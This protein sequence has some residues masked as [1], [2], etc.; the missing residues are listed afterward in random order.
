MSK[1]VVGFTLA[2]AL[3]LALTLPLLGACSSSSTNDNPA[4]SGGTGGT[5]NG[6]TGAGGIGGGA[7]VCNTTTHSCQP[8][9]PAGWKAVHVV[10]GEPDPTCSDPVTGGSAISAE[11]FQCSPCSCGTISGGAC[12]TSVALHYSRGSS[13]C[14]TSPSCE[15]DYDQTTDGTCFPVPIVCSSPTTPNGVTVPA[16]PVTSGSCT[17]D[18]VVPPVLPAPVVEDLQSLCTPAVFTADCG[19]GQVCFENPPS[20]AIPRYCIARET[21]EPCPIAYPHERETLHTDVNDTRGCTECDCSL[22]GLACQVSVTHFAEAGC[23]G[24]GAVLEPVTGQCHGFVNW[25]STQVTASVPAD[26]KCTPGG[27]QPTGE[28]AFT[29][30][31]KICCTL[32]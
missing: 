25:D 30:Q 19:T 1:G 8:E 4:N 24:G 11:A 7:G 27:G 12:A 17:P 22:T 21:S 5:G 29:K 26:A 13:S 6:G 16:V 2:L 32:P 14:P 15:L 10:P 9:P 23:A 20:G 28:L 18:G 31:T 3:A